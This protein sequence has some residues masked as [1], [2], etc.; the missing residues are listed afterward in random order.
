MK[1]LYLFPEI[2]L[3][4]KKDCCTYNSAQQSYFLS[5]YSFL[6]P[7]PAVLRPTRLFSDIASA[8]L[9]ILRG[10]SAFTHHKTEFRIICKP[11]R[12]IGIPYVVV[13]IKIQVLY[14]GRVLPAQ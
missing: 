13:K 1:F 2:L 10:Q 9:R 7:F 5:H 3:H 4:D 12:E 14:F 6:M 8:A 11:H